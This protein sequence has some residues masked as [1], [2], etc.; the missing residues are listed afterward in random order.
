[1]KPRGVSN[2]ARFFLTRQPNAALIGIVSI[3]AVDDRRRRSRFMKRI[4]TAFTAASFAVAL[5]IPAFAQVGAGVAGNATVGVSGPHAGANAD[6][7]NSDAEHA[8]PASPTNSTPPPTTHHRRARHH[9][10]STTTASTNHSA[11]ANSGGD[12]SPTAGR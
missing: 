9:Q 4:L 11:D 10:A 6:V 7:A 3:Y 5:A 2:A 8:E 1:M 12:S